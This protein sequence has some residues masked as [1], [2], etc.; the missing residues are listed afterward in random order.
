MHPF[1]PAGGRGSQAQE[2]ETPVYDGGA[3][4][5]KTSEID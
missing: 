1:F 5:E 2:G 3:E 4:S